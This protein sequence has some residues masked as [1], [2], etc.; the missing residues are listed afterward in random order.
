[1]APKEKPLYISVEPNLYR[2]SKAGLLNSQ[3][4]LLNSMK[5]LHTLKDI[6]NEKFQHKMKLFNLFPSLLA[7]LNRLEQ[8]FPKVA[9]PKEQSTPIQ[10]QITLPKEEV[11]KIKSIKTIAKRQ[12]IEDELREIQEKLKRLNS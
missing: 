10:K 11:P 1:M 4:D 8:K 2:D 9:S 5:H 6:K 12:S 7:D 3:I